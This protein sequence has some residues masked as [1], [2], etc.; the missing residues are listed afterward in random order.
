MPTFRF[1][2]FFLV[3]VLL[4]GCSNEKAAIPE[5]LGLSAPVFDASVEH[6]FG[7]AGLSRKFKVFRLEEE[8]YSEIRK[9]GLGFLNNMQSAIAFT[10]QN[11]KK[12]SNS[13]RWWISFSKWQ[14]LPV[15]PDA[16]WLSAPRNRATSPIALDADTFFG[17]EYVKG[18]RFSERIPKEILN[19]FQ[20]AL[21]ST[22]GYFSYGGYKGRSLMVISTSNM[23]VYYLF[24]G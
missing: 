6:S 12:K 18:A 13:P 2:C 22:D 7:P 1:L 4:L 14:E 23:K 11:E 10:Q 21:A 20:A 24:R 5:E 15:L 17:E 19:A 3:S 9:N 8:T 16:Q